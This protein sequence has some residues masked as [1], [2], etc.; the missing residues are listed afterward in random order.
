MECDRAV[1]VMPLPIKHGIMVLF[2]DISKGTVYRMKIISWNCRGKFREKYA[3]LEKMDADIYVIQECE[4]PE[5]Y[6]K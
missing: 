3:V 4:N 1:S 6:K 5:K 2:R